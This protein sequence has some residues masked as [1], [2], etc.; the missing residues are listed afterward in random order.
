MTGYALDT[1]WA[2]RSFDRACKTYDASAVLQGEVR[3]RLLERLDRL[4]ADDIATSIVSFHEQAQGCLAYIHRARR[5]DQIVEAYL[6]LE[7]IWRW[8]LKM[9]VL[10]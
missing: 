10:S 1:V 9:N 7:T 4:P 3:E 2:R 5:A 8:F 6:K